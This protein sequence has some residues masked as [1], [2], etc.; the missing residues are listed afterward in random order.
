[1]CIGYVFEHAIGLLQVDSFAVVIYMSVTLLY[2]H[3]Y[4]G[5]ARW[6]HRVNAWLS[7]SHTGAL[8]NQHELTAVVFKMLWHQ[9]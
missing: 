9:M 8:G 3:L 5:A 4:V 2:T 1:M 6:Q 7:N